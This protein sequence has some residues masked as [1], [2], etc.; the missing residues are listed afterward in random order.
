MGDLAPDVS[1]MLVRAGIRGKETPFAHDGYSGA[2]M[3]RIQDGG[4]AYIIKRVS[5]TEDWIIQMTSDHSLR[6]A[7]I[8][9]SG[10]LSELPPGLRSP[11]IDAA[12]DGDG[13]ALLMHDLTPYL[14]PT[15]GLL[16]ESTADLV[17]QR[18]AAM[19]ARFWDAPPAQDIGWCGLQG[20]LL[21][22][23]EDAGERLRDADLMQIGFAAGWERFHAA[24][25]VPVSALVRRIQRDPKPL[26]RV[27]SQLPQTLLHNDVKVANLAIQD[28]T[29]W[30]FDWALAGVG[31][32]S[33]ELAWV[34]AVNSSRLPWSL[35]ATI[36]RYRDHL[37][38]ELGRPVDPEEW[39][40]QRAATLICG[41]VM[42]GWAKADD[43]AE[44]NWWCEGAMKA[45]GTLG[46]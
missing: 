17:L 40:M 6:E 9:V 28:E 26:L 35:E 31:P 38:R 5:R 42:F 23:S 33:F 7:Q 44:L 32:V 30:M 37:N 14:L 22:L 27:L 3:S 43:A 13:F 19:H 25:P 11:S 15:A 45:A 8:A 1:A 36:S 16:D 24:A 29:L 41:I 18:T 4:C 21:M 10:L 12:R 39:A 46:L 2:A 34:L 20:R